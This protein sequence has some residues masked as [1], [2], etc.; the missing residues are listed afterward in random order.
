MKTLQKITVATVFPI[1]FN[2][3]SAIAGGSTQ[4]SPAN[5][6]V[7]IS[8]DGS[9]PLEFD[10]H[11]VVTNLG[12]PNFIATEPPEIAL[13]P[14][15]VELAAHAMTRVLPSLTDGF[16][17]GLL[18]HIP[19]NSRVSTYVAGGAF[20]RRGEQATDSSTESEKG[21]DPMLQLGLT[22]KLTPGVSLT[23]E[24]QRYWKSEDD[25]IERYGV[26]LVYTY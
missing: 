11:G 23:G 4:I 20:I 19:V 24:V 6:S 16:K 1:L 14:G 7:L 2:V 8:D 26:S 5:F 12:Y 21:I 22:Y 13:R 15:E 18:R 9:E 17:V 10:E 25:D 3:G